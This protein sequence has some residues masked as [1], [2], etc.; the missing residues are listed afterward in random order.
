MKSIDEIAAHMRETAANRYGDVGNVSQLQH[1]LQCAQLAEAQGASPALISAALLHDIGH[2]VDRHFEGAAAAGI[3]R[4]HEQ[5][6]AAYLTRWFDADVVEPIRLHVAAKRYLCAVDDE[7]FGGLSTG[8]VRSLKLQGGPFNGPHATA[9][10]NQPYARDAVRL[11]RWDDL[12]KT[13]DAVTPDLDH[14]LSFVAVA[15]RRQQVA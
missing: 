1:A 9:F 12:A 4:K 2:V 7:Y 10:I 14:Y 5:V 6:G 11:R 3:D 15:M 13:P 8:S